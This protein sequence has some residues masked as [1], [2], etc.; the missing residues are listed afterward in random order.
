MSRTDAI[1]AVDGVVEV[2]KCRMCESDDLY[3][4]FDMGSMPAPNGFLTE[5]QLAE[6]EPMFPLGVQLCEECGLVQLTHTVPPETMFAHYMY[7]PSTSRTM[8]LHFFHLTRSIVSRFGLTSDDLVVDIGSNDGTLLS[9]FKE[10][11]VSLL[12]ID[13]ASNLAAVANNRGV[14]TISA[15]FNSDIV[16]RV[17]QE[18]G[19]V[20]VV[21][22][23]N[24]MAHVPDI[25]GFVAA[26]KNLLRPDGIFI[27]EFP[28]AADMIG[29]DQF[30]TIYHEHV[31]YFMVRPLRRLFENHGLQIVDI[32]RVPIHGGSIR[33]FVRHADD[34]TAS[35]GAVK[36]FLGAELAGGFRE[37]TPYD[38]FAV[39]AREVREEA[40]AY[41]MARKEQGVRVIGYGA[42]AKATVFLNFADIGP[43]LMP[44]I[45]DSIPYKIGL[46][47]PGVRIPIRAE[48]EFLDHKPE[49]ALI[50]P[51]NF[52]EEIKAKN[53]Q[54]TRAGGKFVIAIP[55]LQEV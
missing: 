19:R 6:K 29:G 38:R 48:S 42:P 12:G 45:V 43:T 28:Y 22:A 30:D 2:A 35:S 51:W 41:L 44:V 37:H 25:N 39:R 24:V 21:T 27:A 32:E 3:P 13:P 7:V 20:R 50:F 52:A 40:C 34:S 47:V 15:F 31:F 17:V 26:V 16:E 36:K 54:F 10:F 55:R 1:K 33:V 4:F 23:T 8:W 49:V 46:F 9:C 18:Y 53:V 14:P 5:A 11:G